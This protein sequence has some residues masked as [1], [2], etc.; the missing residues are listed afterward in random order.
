MNMQKLE[1]YAQQCLINKQPM[2]LL[3]GMSEFSAPELQVNPPENI[4]KKLEYIRNTYDE[5]CEHK[6]AKGICI[7]DVV[8]ST[9]ESMSLVGGGYVAELHEGESIL[10]DRQSNTLRSAGMFSH[11]SQVRYSQSS[12]VGEVSNDLNIEGSVDDV[13]KVLEATHSKKLT[14]DITFNIAPHTQVDELVNTI[15][16]EM[17]R[18]LS[19]CL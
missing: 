8:Y 7:V 6:H 13:L 9:E 12:Y 19:S 2:Q 10:T 3:I 15:K 11:N 14:S 5:N 16:K 1:L 4:E 18:H 17:E